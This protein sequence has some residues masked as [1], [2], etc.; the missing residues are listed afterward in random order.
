MGLSQHA[1]ER[2]VV[3]GITHVVSSKEAVQRALVA[4]SNVM[5]GVRGGAVWVL[6]IVPTIMLVTRLLQPVLRRVLR[7]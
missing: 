7:T 1:E 2:L 6:V 4:A 5:E 3:V